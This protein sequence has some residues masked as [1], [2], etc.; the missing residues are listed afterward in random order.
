MESKSPL[1]TFQKSSNEALDLRSSVIALVVFHN[2]TRSS[3]STVGDGT[4][5]SYTSPCSCSWP[6]A[7]G[8]PAG[9][10]ATGNTTTLAGVHTNTQKRPSNRENCCK[11]A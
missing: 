2:D 6:N 9:S 5:N 4:A 3:A 1:F 11:P 7:P 8:L 10:A